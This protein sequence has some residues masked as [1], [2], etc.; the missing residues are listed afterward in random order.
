[1]EVV[2]RVSSIGDSTTQK[3]RNC[4]YGF[5]SGAKF[6]FAQQWGMK[7]VTPQWFHDS[8]D[9][10]YC[11]PEDTYTV[12]SGGGEKG[13]SLGKATAKSAEIP[14]WASALKAFKIPDIAGE[15]FLSGCKVRGHVGVAR[16]C[17]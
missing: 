1:M 15:E 17:G 11:M 2:L 16:R 6:K 7:C 5:N 12:D 3:S 13:R 4:M 9:A 8:V 14:E 10:G